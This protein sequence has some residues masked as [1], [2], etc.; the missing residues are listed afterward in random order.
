[1]RHHGGSLEEKVADVS[2]SLI[3]DLGTPIRH[4]TH[5]L[6]I[7]QNRLFNRHFTQRFPFKGI[8]CM[9]NSRIKANS[10][11]W[12]KTMFV[13]NLVNMLQSSQIRNCTSN[14]RTSNAFTKNNVKS[15]YIQIINE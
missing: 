14:N 5:Q 15:N 8:R 13:L 4:L 3:E 2:V 9:V 7:A 10:L 1:M 12:K 11:N 6:N